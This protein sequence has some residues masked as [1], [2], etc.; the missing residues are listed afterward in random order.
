MIDEKPT[1][2]ACVG[3][4]I[5]FGLGLPS[6]REECYP[7]VLGRLLGE[8]CRV[9]NFGYSGA[10][11]GRE[12]NE[13]YWQ[14]PSMTAAT[15]F[16][17]QVVVLMLGTNDAQVANL[18]AAPTF[19]RDYAELI[20]HFRLLDSRPDIVTISPPPV[21]EP[22]PAIDIEVLDTAIRPA[23]ERLAGELGLP[24]VDAYEPLRGHPEWF[25]DNLHPNADGARVIAERVAEVLRAEVLE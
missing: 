10:T 8:R 6:R 15:R 13:P 7:A 12:T 24:L 11:A 1:T 16:E 25:P 14:T 2:I 9:R 20:E 18:P 19:E 17:P 22:L 23:V 3:A 4:S 5:T 21:F